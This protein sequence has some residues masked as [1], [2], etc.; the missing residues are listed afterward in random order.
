MAA[1]KAARGETAFT[2]TARLLE[3]KRYT[4]T[5]RVS[6]MACDKREAKKILK[7][8][9]S[10]VYAADVKVEVIDGPDAVADGEA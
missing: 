4:G 8:L 3:Q 9:S 5:V 7:G 6:V 2:M 1:K 10:A